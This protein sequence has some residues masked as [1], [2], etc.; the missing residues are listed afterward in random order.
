[1]VGKSVSDYSF[2]KKEQVTTLSS[3]YVSVENEKIE[4]N[5]QQLYQRLLVAGIE[6]VELNTLFQY[7]LSAYPT[8]LFDQKLLMR[9]PDKADLQNGIIKKVPQCVV[10]ELPTRSFYVI[11][12]GAMLQRLTWP[13][14]ASYEAL[15][16]IYVR[17]IKSNNC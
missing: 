2:S 14:S 10:K 11:D 15:C 5:P 12:G 4:I 16:Q 3:L 13:R 17:Y 9:V 1:M 8:S 7:E 6:S